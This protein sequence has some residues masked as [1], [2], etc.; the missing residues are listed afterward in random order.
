MPRQPLRVRLLLAAVLFAAA[1]TPVLAYAQDEASALARAVKATFLYKF[2]PFIEWP[3]A[4]F[5]SATSPV[6]ICIVG[7]D[8]FGRLVERAA[9][10]QRVGERRVVVRVLAAA[11]TEPACHVMYVGSHGSEPVATTLARVRGRPVLTVT[12][13][14]YGDSMGIVHFVIRDGRVRF[15]IDNRLARQEHLTISPK[16]LELAI[17]VIK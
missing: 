13:E 10:G 5:P 4:A 15:T 16:L 7:N 14:S 12:D 17:S 2:V 11:Q 6:D 9:A 1:S 3:G 8:S